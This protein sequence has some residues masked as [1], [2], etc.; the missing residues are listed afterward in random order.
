MSTAIKFSTE[1]INK[2]QDLRTRGSR[3]VME[4]GQL[5]AELF[6]LER[7]KGQ[8]QETKQLITNRY[9]AMQREEQQLVQELNK[10]Y[11]SGT[12]DVESGEFIPA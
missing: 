10:K 11:G 2:I 3:L 12:V 4:L 9:L 5:E 8:L 7:Q 6:M 1:E